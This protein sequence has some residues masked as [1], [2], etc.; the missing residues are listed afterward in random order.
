MSTSGWAPLTMPVLV[1]TIPLLVRGSF[2]VALS[3]TLVIEGLIVLV[4]GTARGLRIWHWL[5]YA[6]LIN[7]VTQ[8]VLWNLMRLLPAD[9]PYF[10]ALAV[11]ESLVWVVEAVPL[12]LLGGGHLTLRKALHLSVAMNVVS[13]GVGLLLP[14]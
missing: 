5:A 6:A 4:Y 10:P 2:E 8:P 1:R 12:R 13:C 9:M 14:V 7:L 3:A 11:G